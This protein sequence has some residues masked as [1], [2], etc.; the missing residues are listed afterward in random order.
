MV[1]VEVVTVTCVLFSWTAGKT[2]VVVLIFIQ[3]VEIR[4]VKNPRKIWQGFVNNFDRNVHYF[5]DIFLLHDDFDKNIFKYSTCKSVEL[6]VSYY[7]SNHWS[8]T[9]KD[10]MNALSI[11]LTNP[12]YFYT[13]NITTVDKAWLYRKSMKY[14][15][16]TVPINV[17]R[18]G[19]LDE[20]YGVR[21]YW[22]SQS[23]DILI[24][25]YTLVYRGI[26]CYLI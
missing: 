2:S 1:L 6:D 20:R 25:V 16:I 9:T 24:Y 11:F 12:Y 7:I 17:H 21:V 8:K 3:I 14:Y 15:N 5:W 23:Y 22:I 19:L 26:Y 18:K 13:I 10:I 4:C